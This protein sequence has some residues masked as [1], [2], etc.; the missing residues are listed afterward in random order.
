ME[1]SANKEWRAQGRE[2]L[3]GKRLDVLELPDE[4]A[5][6]SSG[7]SLSSLGSGFQEGFSYPRGRKEGRTRTLFL[8]PQSEQ[9]EGSAWVDG[10]TPSSEFIVMR[11]R[12]SSC[13]LF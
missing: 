4:K 1:V 9:S 7:D 6:S 3:D 2:G 13:H 12:N 5:E 8:Q 11:F 10:C